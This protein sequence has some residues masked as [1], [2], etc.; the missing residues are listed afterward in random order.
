MAE[1]PDYFTDMLQ[2]EEEVL[3]TLAAAGVTGDTWYQ[4]AATPR[5]VLAV[6]LVRQGEGA[7]HPAA[8]LVAD[9]KAVRVRHV[10]REQHT[11]ARLELQGFQEPVVLSDV[12]ASSVFPQVEPFL[13][14]WGGT[15]EEAGDA[16]RRAHGAATAP[17]F[18]AVAALGF[19][20]VAVCACGGAVAV[21]VARGLGAF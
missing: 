6:K 15:L 10:P 11:G 18:L 5:R 19:L 9:K 16:A 3:A 12:D 8:R 13:G 21:L 17:V 14:A 4:L 20:A 7:Y 2:G 1:A